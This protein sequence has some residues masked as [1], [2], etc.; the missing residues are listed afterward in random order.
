VHEQRTNLLL[1][2]SRFLQPAG[3]FHG[4]VRIGD[5]DVEL[6]GVPGVVEDQDVLW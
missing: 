2:R 5:R 4:T 3:A 6:D 1:V